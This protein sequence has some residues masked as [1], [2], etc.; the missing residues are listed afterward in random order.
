MK[1]YIEKLNLD[2]VK[3]QNLDW[4]KVYTEECNGN[5]IVRVSEYLKELPENA[6]VD[7][8]CGLGGTTYALS[9]YDKVVIV[10][11]LRKLIN[12]KF[13]KF[14]EV[15]KVEEGVTKNDICNVSPNKI[16]TTYN[17][18]YK[19][20]DTINISDY[21]LVVD[22]FHTIVTNYDAEVHKPVLEH[23]KEFKS[24]CFVSATVPFL[25]PVELK[26]LPVVKLSK[27]TAKVNVKLVECTSPIIE[28]INT[29]KDILSNRETLQNEKTL[30]KVFFVNSVNVIETILF[31]CDE[32]NEENCNVFYGESNN[33]VLRLPNSS[34][35]SNLK[36]INIITSCGFAGIDINEPIEDV[37]FVSSPS[38]NY[39]L[40]NMLDIKQALGRFRTSKEL[41]VTHFY[42]L[43]KNDVTGAKEAL[44]TK[45]NAAK[46]IEKSNLSEDALKWIIPGL[47]IYKGKYDEDAVIAANFN[48]V[49]KSM[50]T[51][52]NCLSL[53][54]HSIS[55]NVTN[56]TSAT[57]GKLKTCITKE[58]LIELFGEDKV[59]ELGVRELKKQI[60]EQ[61]IL[62]SKL[63]N[64]EKMDLVTGK[65]YPAKS[66]NIK[67]IKGFYN[68]KA[69]THRIDG[70]AT[71][72]YL[73]L[74]KTYKMN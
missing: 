49:R 74:G 72:C 47:P 31:N 35:F 26:E 10:M 55:K 5:K 14:P 24:Y 48:I 18:F 40:Y 57:V 43:M 46:E 42:K 30:H 17:S 25:L 41:N 33:K 39:T 69:V 4:N 37:Y 58:Q 16:I 28:T 59:D 62:N 71:R 38:K 53:V 20:L 22:E 6:I 11:P 3:H 27:P 54:Y 65:Y 61:E 50:W 12:Q 68:Y 1:E 23:F 67:D 8:S 19:L 56:V 7:K 64:A 34:D 70:I 44:Q 52:N 60:K 32:L 29:I 45:I 63:L 51:T 66:I 13:E 15:F 21:R 36:T 73:I 2:G 9:H